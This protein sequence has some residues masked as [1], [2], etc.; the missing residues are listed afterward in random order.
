[1]TELTPRVVII[2]D[3]ALCRSALRD[4]LTSPAGKMTVLAT[5]ADPDEAL[6][7]LEDLL[8]DLV[9]VD[10]RIGAKSGL[11]LLKEAKARL[12]QLRFVVLTMSEDTDDLAE[13]LRL[14]ASGYLL[15]SMDPDDLLDAIRRAARGELVVAPGMSAQIP[16]LFARNEQ[17]AQRIGL[18]EQLTDREVEILSF[19][20]QGMSNKQIARLLGISPDTVKLH[21]RHILAKLNLPTRVAAAVYAVEHQLV[22]KASTS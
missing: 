1:M 16:A 22:S 15:K 21:V 18:I 4:L 20:A 17:K 8:P 19:I 7:A 2:E 3:H 14:G 9:L 13:A 5:F 6:A 12:P 10:I 11:A